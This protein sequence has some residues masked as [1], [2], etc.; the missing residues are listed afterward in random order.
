MDGV[1]SRL[2]IIARIQ[3]AAC[4]ASR[5]ASREAIFCGYRQISEGE[6]FGPPFV[7]HL[8]RKKGTNTSITP[9]TRHL[10]LQY[11]SLSYYTVVKRL[12]REG[13]STV[14]G[15]KIT[16]CMLRGMPWFGKVERN[17]AGRK[18]VFALF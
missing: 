5:G 10:I 2:F 11:L 8:A 6:I 7:T 14:R 13:V 15:H 4:G 18:E 1:R 3:Y 16:Q 17:G 12:A 9:H